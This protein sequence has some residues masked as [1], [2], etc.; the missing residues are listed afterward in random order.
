MKAHMA[1][2]NRVLTLLVEIAVGIVVVA[3]ALVYAA[4]GPFTWVPHRKWITL[5]IITSAVFGIPIWW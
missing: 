2:K 1:E 5:A 4:Y 3:I